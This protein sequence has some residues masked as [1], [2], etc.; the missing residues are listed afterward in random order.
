[1][2]FI[3]Q[4][5]EDESKGQYTT[6]E[7][8][9]MC[10]FLITLTKLARKGHVQ[11]Y[12]RKY[13][14]DSFVYGFIRELKH[15]ITLASDKFGRRLWLRHHFQ[16]RIGEDVCPIYILSEK[17]IGAFDVLLEQLKDISIDVQ[18]HESAVVDSIMGFYGGLIPNG[19][20]N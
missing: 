7:D 19:T 12:Y 4:Y 9:E 8:E 18:D 3:T 13:Y 16:R 15:E 6:G 2:N 1:M 5:W 14:T 17:Q 10:S 11:A 20:K